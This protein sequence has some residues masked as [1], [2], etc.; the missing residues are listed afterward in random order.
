[1]REDVLPGRSAVTPEMAVRIG[2]LCGNGSVV[3]IR[4]Q[5]A[6]DLLGAERRLADEIEAIPT[7]QGRRA[8]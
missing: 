5:E 4:L 7:L 3:W 1:M 2:K 6:Y 8:A